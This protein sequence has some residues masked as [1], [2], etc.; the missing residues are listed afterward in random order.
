MPLPIVSKSWF[1]M[2]Y[3]HLKTVFLW[4]LFLINQLIFQIVF[5]LFFRV[6]DDF[7]PQGCHVPVYFKLLLSISFLIPLFVVYWTSRRFSVFSKLWRPK[8]DPTSFFS[9]P[10]TGSGDD[11][12]RFYRPLFW[13][14]VGIFLPS[15]LFVLQSELA[16]WSYILFPDESRLNEMMALLSPCV[17]SMADILGGYITIGIVGPV[18]EE[19][20]FRGII[21][22]FLL[23]HYRSRGKTALVPI[24]FQAFLFSVA[25]MNPLQMFYAFSAGLVFGVVALWTGSLIFPILLHVINN[26]MTLFLLHKFPD[27][28][29]VGSPQGTVEHI[30]P[31]FLLISLLLAGVS[32]YFIRELFRTGILIKKNDLQEKTS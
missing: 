26:S 2:H 19:I 1:Q 24:L 20:L 13:L 15:A 28:P 3:I 4:L 10:A 14:T 27:L 30:P 21:F 31:E 9:L 22:H 6:Q 8:S 32:L 5:L 11:R 17:D 12:K 16:T 25:H 23:R 7:S 29:Y 18:C